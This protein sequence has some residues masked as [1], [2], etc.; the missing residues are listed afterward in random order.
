MADEEIQQQTE[1]KPK[2]LAEAYPDFEEKYQAMNTLYQAL[3]D[4]RKGGSDTGNLVKQGQD[5]VKWARGVIETF[6]PMS[7]FEQKVRKDTAT[8]SLGLRL[9][10]DELLLK[11]LYLSMV[12]VQGVLEKLK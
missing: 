3:R 6:V 5:T 12:Q 10:K 4:A 8:F 9:D 7:E 2:T 1:E 11:Q